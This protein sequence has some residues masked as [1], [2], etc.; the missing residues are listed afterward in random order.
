MRSDTLGRIAAARAAM[1]RRGHAALQLMIGPETWADLLR[2]TEE[3][4]SAEVFGLQVV[5][6]HDLEGFVVVPVE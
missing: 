6:C 3:A 5:E 4:E 1:R 2:E